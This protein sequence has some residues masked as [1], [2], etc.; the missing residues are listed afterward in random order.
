MPAFE[1]YIHLYILTVIKTDH[2]EEIFFHIVGTTSR[3]NKFR[4]PSTEKRNI[5]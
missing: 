5:H 3:Q 4:K 1:E 2:T